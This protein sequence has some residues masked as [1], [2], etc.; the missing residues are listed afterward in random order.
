MDYKGMLIMQNYKN[1]HN[2][3]GQGAVWGQSSHA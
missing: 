1:V 2:V 3:Y